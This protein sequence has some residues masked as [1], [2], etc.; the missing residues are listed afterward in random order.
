MVCGSPERVMIR[1]RKRERVCVVEKPQSQKRCSKYRAG[2]GTSSS[3]SRLNMGGLGRCWGKRGMGRQQ[4]PPRFKAVQMD[5]ARRRCND[6]Q[7]TC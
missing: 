3:E 1:D 6:G 2:T 5:W 4:E 7:R